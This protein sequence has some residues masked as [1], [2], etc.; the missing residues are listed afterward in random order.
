MD[1][2]PEDGGA[3]DG[4]YLMEGSPRPRG[5]ENAIFRNEK[6]TNSRTGGPPRGWGGEPYFLETNK[7]RIDKAYPRV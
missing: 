1:L 4:T 6:G 5:G 2:L 7:K 3:G